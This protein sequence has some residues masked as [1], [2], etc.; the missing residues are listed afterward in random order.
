M[1][2]EPGTLLICVG[3]DCRKKKKLA[4]RLTELLEDKHP[5]KEVRCQDICSGL[6]TG[7]MFRDELHWVKKI[8]SKK[9][10]QALVESLSSKKLPSRI[11]AKLVKKRTGKL[12]V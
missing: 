3:K 10:A 12:K 4:R 11:K 6:V 2:I 8:Q 5:V 9:D 7:F 1:P